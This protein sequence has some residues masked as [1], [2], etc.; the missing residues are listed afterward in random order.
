MCGYVSVCVYVPSITQSCP[1]L[2]DPMD[3]KPTRL[4][5]P[6]HFPNK[7]IGVGCHFLLQEIFLILG[8]IPH[9][10]R[11]LHWQT[12]SLPLSH[13]DMV[14]PNSCVFLS[15]VLNLIVLCGCSPDQGP[16]LHAQLCPRLFA[17]HRLLFSEWS[18][19]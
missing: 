1:T 15:I 17:T 4:L 10:L 11:L 7:N 8:S 3:S 16:N 12:D 6:W 2:C 14:S 9:L 18:P 5:C 13:L 19:K